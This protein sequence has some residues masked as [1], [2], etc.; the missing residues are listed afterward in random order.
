ML[1]WLKMTV[2]SSSA[3]QLSYS[4]GAVSAP[5]LVG[6]I[7]YR[8]AFTIVAICSLAPIGTSFYLTYLWLCGVLL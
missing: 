1:E 4:A 2:F 3:L 7:P 6:S 5:L 8:L